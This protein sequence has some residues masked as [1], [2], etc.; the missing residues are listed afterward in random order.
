M[1]D[2]GHEFTVRARRRPQNAEAV[3]D[4]MKGDALDEARQHFLGR[5]RLRFH[6][7]YCVICCGRGSQGAIKASRLR[8][9]TT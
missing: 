9:P 4:I 5:F 1:T 3:L 8:Q 2:Q 7:N 6:S